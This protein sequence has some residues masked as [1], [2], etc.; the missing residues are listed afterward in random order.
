LSIGAQVQLILIFL[1]RFDPIPGHDLPLR[2]FA[3]T[4]IGHTTLDEIPLAVWSAR[5]RDLYLTTDNNHNRQISMIPMGFEPAKP[6]SQRLQTHA[7]DR[8]AT[9]I[10]HSVRLLLC[11]ILREKSYCSTVKMEATGSSRKFEVYLS[12]KTYCVMSHKAVTQNVQLGLFSSF[13]PQDSLLF[14]NQI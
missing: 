4:L 7:L 11:Y 5:R 3:I 8:A 12:T 1:W 2:G 9:R 10:R 14:A 6:A 13:K